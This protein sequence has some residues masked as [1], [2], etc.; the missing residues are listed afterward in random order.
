MARRRA[1]SG[2]PARV[3]FGNAFFEHFLPK[4]TIA[5]SSLPESASWSSRFMRCIPLLAALRFRSAISPEPIQGFVNL[6]AEL[7]F[8]TVSVRVF[9]KPCNISPPDAQNA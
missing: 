3:G 2:Q 9:H 6:F 5:F 4:A 8:R 1:R 7:H